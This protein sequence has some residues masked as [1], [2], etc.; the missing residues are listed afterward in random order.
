MCIEVGSFAA[1]TPLSD[2]IDERNPKIAIQVGQRIMPTAR[3]SH[4]S[5]Q[6][7]NVYRSAR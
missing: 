3:L 6:H 1:L 7:I 5:I 4:T 2:A